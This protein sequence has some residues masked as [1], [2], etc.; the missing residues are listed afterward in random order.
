M[1]SRTA[2]AVSQLAN[3]HAGTVDRNR[4]SVGTAVGTT[5]E[6]GVTNTVTASNEL[7][8]AETVTGTARKNH[9]IPVEAFTVQVI[10][11]LTCHVVLGHRLLHL[12]PSTIQVKTFPHCNHKG[13]R[14]PSACG[15]NRQIVDVVRQYV[16]PINGYSNAV[17]ANE[18][19]SRKYAYS[20]QGTQS[21]SRFSE[22]RSGDKYAGM[23]K[24]V[25]E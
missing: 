16:Y 14:R 6:T 19:I 2:V 25:K 5:G 1:A 13:N 3:P 4:S 18:A 22:S 15:R 21:L 10:E 11:D 8:S 9:H 17:V 23:V 20:V 12:H 7:Q 24:G